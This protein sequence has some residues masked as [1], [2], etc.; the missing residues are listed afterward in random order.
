VVILIVRHTGAI[1]YYDKALVINPRD[2][3]AL[4][5][6]GLALDNLGNHTGA[7]LYYDKAL[8]I[9]VSCL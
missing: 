6:K 5:D 1:L 3:D 2:V 9:V 7:I 4:T 8:A